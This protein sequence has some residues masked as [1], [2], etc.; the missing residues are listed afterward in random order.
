[1]SRRLAY[2]TA[3]LLSLVAVL[4]VAVAVQ[5]FSDLANRRFD[6]TLTRRLSLSP[7]SRSVLAEVES[8]L[9]ID[10][11]YE[12]GERQ[13]SRDLLELVRDNCAR[14]SYELVDLDR[15]PG[16]AKEHRVDHYD[17]AVLRYEGREIVTSAG[18]EEALIGGIARILHEKPRVLYF[19]TGHRERETTPGK[20]EH[21]GRAAQVLR[22]E[23]Y[24]VLPL[25]L[26]QLRDVPADASAVVLAGPELDLVESELGAL[27]AYLERGGSVLVL[28]D[29]VRLPRLEAWVAR[30][31]LEL[32]D[33]VVIDR[34][35]RVYGSDG[36]NVV[37]PY[38]R[39]HEATRTMDVPTVLGRARSVSIAGGGEDDGTGGATIVAR[40]ANESF[41]A[42][43]ASRTRA[44]EVT[45][46]ESRDRVGPIGVMGVAVVGREPGEVGR[47]AVIGDADF[48]SDAFL[49][50]LGNKDLLV[51][52]IGWLVQERAQGARPQMQ[53]TQLGPMAAMYV[54][55]SLARIIF[56]V[57]VIVQPALVLLVGIAVVVGRR[58]RR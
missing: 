42:Q 34:A 49:S 11:Y 8:P 40:S 58:R 3:F 9:R 14:C 56:A 5:S 23:G 13:R 48:A 18:N 47:L 6:L 57:A 26:L 1:M 33:D 31:G 36:T 50:L 12:R 10:L 25:G 35:N 22:T 29:P 38:Y 45:F 4:A 15:N 41:A 53:M 16:R 39:D 43:D 7:Y 44:G 32:G 20:D 2:W 37:V 54:S 21:L 51:G 19:V 27:S 24:V 46:D 30:W 28:V 17:R 52:T 55:D